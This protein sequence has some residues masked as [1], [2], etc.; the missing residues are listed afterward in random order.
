LRA[1]HWILALCTLPPGLALACDPPS[2]R[3]DSSPAT[4]PTAS[5]TGSVPFGMICHGAKQCI[6]TEC[7]KI[8]DPY[9]D[10]GDTCVGSSCRGICTN[11]CT[12]DADCPANGRCTASPRG[13]LC[14]PRC[15][16]NSDCTERLTCAR[17]GSEGVC[18]DYN[19]EGGEIK[20][21]AELSIV[22]LNLDDQYEVGDYEFASGAWRLIPGV[23]ALLSVGVLNSGSGRGA[24][25]AS[26]R[27]ENDWIEV[28]Y[29]GTALS[30]LPNK[31]QGPGVP[32]P[33]G[34]AEKVLLK[35]RA[36]IPV[37]T[38]LPM[39]LVLVKEGGLEETA[40]PFN[41]T[42]YPSSL[43][44]EI[45]SITA[46]AISTRTGNLDDAGYLLYVYGAAKGF[47]GAA[48]TRARVVSGAS[49]IAV[50]DQLWR[51]FY[52]PQW[53]NG[54][55]F[56]IRDLWQTGS[57]GN[58]LLHALAIAELPAG[59]ITIEVSERPENAWQATL[60]IEV[61]Q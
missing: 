11:T 23:P 36:G 20:F 30:V 7:Y 60:P 45:T 44:V 29:A 32:A 46:T 28:V 49:E 27:A 9:N 6:D 15:E 4:T 48:I 21:R 58:L 3:N 33:S 8:E 25:T 19:H 40:V 10:Q 16:K 26:V 34:W 43:S 55:F 24:Y 39:T 57:G 1:S 53:S 59:P 13:L 38:P 17:A 51:E 22:A 5:A 61:Q 2:D 14:L 31:W 41:L 54:P 47:G 18:W 50:P 12:T 52:D 37:N 35:P 56:G 42:S